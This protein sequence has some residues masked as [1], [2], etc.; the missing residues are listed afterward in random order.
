VAIQRSLSDSPRWLN[1]GLKVA[2]LWSRGELVM[3]HSS[4]MMVQDGSIVVQGNSMVVRGWLAD[5]LR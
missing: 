3:I 5:D 1:G 4:S 2:Q